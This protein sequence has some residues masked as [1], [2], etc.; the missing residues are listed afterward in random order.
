MVSSTT[1]NFW[2]EER[3]QADDEC[4]GLE[5]KACG[6]SPACVYCKSAA[7]GDQCYLK[8]IPYS[9]LILRRSCIRLKLLLG[10]N[11]PNLC[12][13]APRSK[14]VDVFEACTLLVI[15][16][17]K[18]RST[19]SFQPVHKAVGVWPELKRRSICCR[20]MH[21]SSHQPFSLAHGQHGQQC[22]RI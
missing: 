14:L 20:M 13:A 15:S 10:W 17:A 8:V 7:V 3:R 6:E 2:C 1:G 21:E 22:L 18:Y 16:L 11:L 19:S 12:S 4:E 5:E 9:T